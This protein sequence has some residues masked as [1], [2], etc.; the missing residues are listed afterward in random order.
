[1]QYHKD[2]RLFTGY[3]PCIHKRPCTNCNHYDPIKARVVIVSLEAMGAVLRSTCLLKP[4][5]E[6]YPHSHITW[7]TFPISKDLLLNNPYIDQ[8]IEVSPKSLAVLSYLEFDVLFGVDKSIE[9]GALTQVIKAKTKKGF[10]LNPYGVIVPFDE[11]ADYQ[12]RVGL[13]DELKFYINQK[14]ETQQ[15]T[16][17]MGL[18]WKREPYVL[19]LTSNEKSEVKKRKE[20]LIKKTERD[21]S[22]IK[23]FIG[24]NTGSSLLFP[25]KKFTLERAIETIA[26]W[27]RSFPDYAVALLGGPED[28]ERHEAMKKAF[29]HD[30]MVIN[31]PTRDGLRSGVLW[32][33]TADLVFSGCSLGMHIGIGL[34]KPIIAWFGVTCAQEVDLYDKGIKLQADVSCSPCWKK[35]CDKTFKCYDA[36]SVE[37]IK[38]ATAALIN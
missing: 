5:K 37:R 38:E 26:M 33:D 36:V 31:T 1:M 23:G 34:K 11:D 4:I 16:E 20:L 32:M 8:L 30:P 35:S 6:R 2:C 24:Y 21:P 29:T 10:G 19:E 13:D 25:Y 17:T 27:R 12:Y 22:Q 15:L 14:A 28:T 18:P 9:A 7:V 3:K